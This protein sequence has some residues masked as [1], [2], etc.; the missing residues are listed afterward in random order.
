VNPE[1]CTPRA[2]HGSPTS[3]RIWAAS[4]NAPSTT[5]PTPVP[6]VKRLL[7]VTHTTGFRHSSIPIA[8]ATL[9]DLG[10]R[11]GLYQTDFCRTQDDVTRMLT[12]AGLA[13]YDAVFFANTT[14]D[15]GIPDLA[16][17]LAWIQAGHAFLGAH[18][19]TDTFYEWPEYE[20][21][22]GTHFKEHP[23]TQEVRVAVED[24]THPIM[25]GLEDLSTVLEEVYVF[26]TNPRSRAHLLFSLDAASVGADPATADHP[27]AWCAQLG[28]GRT[29]YTALGHFEE[30]WEDARFHRLLLN[31]FRWTAGRT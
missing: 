9:Q 12:P 24:A 22:V 21:L 15:L 13:R 6:A 4:R 30:M 20:Q 2:Q 5:T 16:A 14:G 25:V 23:W 28:A 19:A 31:G 17:F 7:V 27:L 1:P 18:S 3:S 11:S 8:E 26:R 10:V 29:F